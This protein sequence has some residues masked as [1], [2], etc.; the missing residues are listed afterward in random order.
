MAHVAS[1]KSVPFRSSI[2]AETRTLRPSAST[3]RLRNIRNCRRKNEQDDNED[4][5]NK[6]DLISSC[7]STVV[8]G[9]IGRDAHF[10]RKVIDSLLPPPKKNKKSIA[11]LKSA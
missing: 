2:V 11:S 6:T 7:R 9:K 1:A 5:E 4:G 10:V 8:H 3:S